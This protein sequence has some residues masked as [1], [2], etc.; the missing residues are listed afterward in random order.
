MVFGSLKMKVKNLK[1][2]LIVTRQEVQTMPKVLQD[3]FFHLAVE[4]F[5]GTLRSRT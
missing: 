5:L 1:D 3:M 2:M 4:F